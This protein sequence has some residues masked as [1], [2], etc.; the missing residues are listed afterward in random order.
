M[1]VVDQVE[2]IQPNLK[3][4]HHDCWLHLDLHHEISII[5]PLIV[6]MNELCLMKIYLFFFPI[7]DKFST[8]AT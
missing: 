8:Y 1:I 7:E 3:V 2:S 4:F 5:E 6:S